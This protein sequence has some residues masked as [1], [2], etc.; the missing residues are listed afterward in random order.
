MTHALRVTGGNQRRSPIGFEASSGK[1][2]PPGL[3][4]RLIYSDSSLTE[5]GSNDEQDVNREINA[6]LLYV[7]WYLP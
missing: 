7:P 6:S 4:D 3:E 2:E 5:T 1:Y